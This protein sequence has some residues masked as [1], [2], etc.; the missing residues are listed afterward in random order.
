MSRDSKKLDP[1]LSHASLLLWIYAD[2]LS[3][4]ECDTLIEKLERQKLLMQLELLANCHDY[5]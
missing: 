5:P 2:D 3:D 1:D 4:N